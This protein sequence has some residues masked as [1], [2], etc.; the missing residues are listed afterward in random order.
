MKVLIVTEGG[1]NIGF[2][3][4]TRC[5][6]LCQ[7][8]AEKG[9]T[10]EFVINGDDTVV[11]LLKNEEYLLFDWI[12]NKN[13]LLEIAKGVEIIIVDS[14][15]A[16]IS[17]YNDI[18]K[19]VKIP[20]YIDD[21]KRLDY[22]KGIVIN[23]SICA[24]ELAYPGK[25]GTVYLLGHKYIS[26]RKEFWKVSEK[27]INKNISSVLITFGGDDRR[28][29]TPKI[30]KI[31]NEKYPEFIKNVVIGKGFDNLQEIK[32]LKD[33]KTNLIYYPDAETTKEIILES[34]IAISAGGQTLYELAR[35]GVPTIGICFAEN[36][37]LNLEG[38]QKKGFIKYIGWYDDEK[39]LK[40]MI[41]AINKFIL[42]K[43]RV[44]SSEIGRR[45]VDGK[46]VHRV[47]DR[48]YKYYQKGNR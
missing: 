44:K 34:D 24:E 18:S 2:G 31:L 33:R 23:G 30:L 28:D 43:E 17:F 38:W 25:E 10:A 27:Y 5:V 15:Q 11:D 45:Y 29:M 40:K 6:S 7:A 4:I 41:D 14:Y 36:Q 22:P 8:F 3:H 16:D 35:V 48:I 12:K 42:H 26:L 13:K 19:L 46:G 37:R 32:Y 47:V 9:I 39:L 20:V 1:K 21:T